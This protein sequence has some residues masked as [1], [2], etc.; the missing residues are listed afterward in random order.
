[1][2]DRPNKM[3][4]HL[5]RFIDELES[6]TP[7]QLNKY[8]QELSRHLMHR[9]WKT[10]NITELK[11]LFSVVTNKLILDIDIEIDTEDS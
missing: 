8:H 1:M 11:K 4:Q 2:T 5:Q 3:D 9:C 10:L 6:F 7:D